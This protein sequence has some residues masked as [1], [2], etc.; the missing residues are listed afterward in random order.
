MEPVRHGDNPRIDCRHTS[1]LEEGGPLNMQRVAA[2][3]APRCASVAKLGPPS[4]EMGHKLEGDGDEA[5]RQAG[6]GVGLVARQCGGRRG[7]ERP[8]RTP[9][10]SLALRPACRSG[11]RPAPMRPRRYRGGASWRHRRRARAEH[12]REP[13]PE[14]TSTHRRRPRQRPHRRRQGRCRTHSHAH[15][16]HRSRHASRRAA[17]AT[18]PRLPHRLT[19]SQRPRHLLAGTASSSPSPT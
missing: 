14:T 8:R 19:A 17:Q 4:H 1:R 2:S 12:T 6:C 13:P 9:G 11:S 18:L 16:R 15:V 5:R 3:T 10:R 7:H